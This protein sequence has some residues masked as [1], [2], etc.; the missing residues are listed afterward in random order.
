[1]V[2]IR[3][4]MLHQQK[5]VW[6]SYATVGIEVSIFVERSYVP[7]TVNC[8]F[9]EFLEVHKDIILD[10][11]RGYLWKVY[12]QTGSVRFFRSIFNACSSS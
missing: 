8:D 4:E 11:W 3:A 6:C 10:Q 5:A 1:M 9:K 2:K 7:I 12:L